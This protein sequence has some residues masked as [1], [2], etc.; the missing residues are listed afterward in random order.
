VETRGR[1]CLLCGASD[2][3]KLPQELSIDK[4]AV[5]RRLAQQGRSEASKL[6]ATPLRHSKEVEG[7]VQLEAQVVEEDLGGLQ[8][9]PL[10]RVTG[11]AGGGKGLLDEISGAKR[12]LTRTL[13]TESQV[14]DVNHHPNRVRAQVFDKCS[15]VLGKDQG[16]GACPEVEGIRAQLDD[17][18]EG[19][20]GGAGNSMLE[21]RAGED[22]TALLLLLCEALELLR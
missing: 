19:R 20:S 2:A 7:D 8:E 9:L 21:L 15:H 16:A 3:G 17:L 10:C 13:H 5:P 1:H 22:R 6:G 4:T 11:E 12:C 14:V 18:V